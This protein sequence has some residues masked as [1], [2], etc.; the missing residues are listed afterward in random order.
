MQSFAALNFFN[1][2]EEALCLD[3][4]EGCLLHSGV[5]KII[6]FSTFSIVFQQN[7]Y[8]LFSKCWKNVLSQNYTL[9]LLLLSGRAASFEVPL[10]HDHSAREPYAYTLRVTL[11]AAGAAAWTHGTERIWPVPKQLAFLL[12]AVKLSEQLQGTRKRLCG[13]TQPGSPITYFGTGGG[14]EPLLLRSDLD[15]LPCRITKSCRADWHHEGPSLLVRMSV[16]EHSGSFLGGL[17][18]GAKERSISAS[19]LRHQT[20]LCSSN[21]KSPPESMGLRA[22]LIAQILV[23]LRCACNTSLQFFASSHK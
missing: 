8:F 1:D 20:V 6:F 19:R 15:T 4:V 17:P 13:T 10:S 12:H 21:Y 23:R 5:D 3:W 22:V 11:P 9:L 16:L 2:A 14:R 18:D 7:T